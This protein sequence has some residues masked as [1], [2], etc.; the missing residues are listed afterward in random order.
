MYKFENA[1]AVPIVI[2]VDTR[3]FTRTYCSSTVA[4]DVETWEVILYS[5]NI[6]VIVSRC[7]YYWGQNTLVVIFLSLQNKLM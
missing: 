4:K 1:Q 2:S 6:F 7:R 3:V 5:I